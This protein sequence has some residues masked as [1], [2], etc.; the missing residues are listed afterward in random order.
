MINF[1]QKARADGRTKDGETLFIGPFLQ[2]L[3]V[4]QE[5]LCGMCAQAKKLTINFL[6]LTILLSI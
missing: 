5:A 1:Q 4:Q 3:R 6:L 2:L